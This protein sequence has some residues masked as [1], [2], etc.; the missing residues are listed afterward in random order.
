MNASERKELVEATH[1]QDH[2]PVY[3]LEKA[4]M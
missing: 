1:Q 4:A 2:T 3:M